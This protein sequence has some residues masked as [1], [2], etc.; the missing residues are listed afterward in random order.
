M[1]FSDICS[2][3]SVNVQWTWSDHSFLLFFVL[4]KYACILHLEW[5]RWAV[6]PDICGSERLWLHEKIKCWIF[7]IFIWQR[8]AWAC[9]SEDVG[10]AEIIWPLVCVCWRLQAEREIRPVSDISRV[11]DQHTRLRLNTIMNVWLH[12]DEVKQKHDCFSAGLM[13]ILVVLTEV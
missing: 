5:I 3:M 9:L 12:V 6:C 13:W 7:V 11:R 1:L 2:Y 8:M 10:Y 4:V